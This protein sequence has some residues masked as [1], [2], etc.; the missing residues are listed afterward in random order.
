MIPNQNI[1]FDSFLKEIVLD[2]IKMIPNQNNCFI[3]INNNNVLDY[4]KMI[5]NQNILFVS[6]LLK[7]GF[8]LHKNDTKPKL[9]SNDYMSFKVIDYI[10]MIPNQN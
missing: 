10:K 8:R 6:S 1:K 9:T 3:Y 5:P 7:S 4:I 2:Y